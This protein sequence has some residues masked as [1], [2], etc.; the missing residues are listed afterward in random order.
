MM[1]FQHKRPLWLG[2]GNICLKGLDPASYYAR[3]AQLV[4]QRTENPR[5]GGSSPPPGTT[6]PNLS[7][8]SPASIT[9]CVG[10][11]ILSLF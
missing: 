4:E 1:L 3:V 5:V 6:F 10:W 9:A 2:R 11:L 8:S 7:F